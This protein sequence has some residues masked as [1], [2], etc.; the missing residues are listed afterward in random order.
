MA[1]RDGR[2]G[3]V[4][5]KTERGALVSE[6]ISHLLAEAVALGGGNLCAAGH[7]WQSDGGRACPKDGFGS[8]D[9]CSQTIYRCSRCGVHDY[10]DKG[11]PAHR[12][13]FVEC[14]YD[15]SDEP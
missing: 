8:G 10:G 4:A 9:G 12:E 13:C 15:V 14:R 6:S 1:N 2:G 11:G 5:Q 7:D 3:D